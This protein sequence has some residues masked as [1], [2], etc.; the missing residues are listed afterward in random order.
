MLCGSAIGAACTSGRRCCPHACF[1]WPAEARS[2]YRN[3]PHPDG[4]LQT[5]R[6]FSCSSSGMRE[7]LYRRASAAPPLDLST[8]R[9]SQQPA[10]LTET[11]GGGGGRS[12][13]WG[14]APPHGG[15]GSGWRRSSGDEDDDDMDAGAVNPFHRRALTPD[16][17]GDYGCCLIRTIAARC[18][19][20][21][22]KY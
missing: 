19:S 10:P 3:Q 7:R 9:R 2:T 8:K 12:R 22:L 15:G 14:G 11:A 21:E 1:G 17:G 18:I 13:G 20:T 16:R 6:R 5:K 4:R